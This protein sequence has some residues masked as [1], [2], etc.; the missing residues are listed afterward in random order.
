MKKLILAMCVLGVQMAIGQKIAYIE[1]DLILEKM[2]SYEE[3][4]KAVEAQASVWESE[5]DTKFQS[6]ENMYQEYVNN[7][8][9]L[10]EEMR[11]KEKM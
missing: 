6:I 7:E 4:G 5:L 10:S 2:P 11:K 8:R 1:T 9:N 3:A